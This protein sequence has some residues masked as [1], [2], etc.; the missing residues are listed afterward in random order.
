MKLYL[1]FHCGPAWY[2]NVIRIIDYFWSHFEFELLMLLF[3][4]VMI[5]IIRKG[6]FSKS[7]EKSWSGKTRN[8]LPYVCYGHFQFQNSTGTDLL[9]Y[10]SY[11]KTAWWSL[12]YG[13][14]LGACE[15][16]SECCTVYWCTQ[17]GVWTNF[18]IQEFFDIRC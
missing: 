16:V 5:S 7:K 3:F 8:L 2:L 14:A 13:W 1:I 12:C 17:W 4:F 6:H 10:Y 15:N 9:R 18:V 11:T